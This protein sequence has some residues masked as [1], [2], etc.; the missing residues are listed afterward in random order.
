MGPKYRNFEN[1][2]FK[3]CNGCVIFENAANLPNYIRTYLYVYLL[4]WQSCVRPGRPALEILSWQFCS[5]VFSAR[6]IL[7]VLFY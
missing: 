7:G 4:P 2:N 1:K 6:P 3:V 5:V